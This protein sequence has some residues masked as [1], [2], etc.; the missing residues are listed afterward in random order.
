MATIKTS[1]T[2]VD[3][4]KLGILKDFLQNPLTNAEMVTLASTLGVAHKGLPVYNITDFKIY[5]WN[6]SAFTTNPVTQTGLTPK[7]SVAFN[8]TEPVAPVVGDLYVFTNAG[9]NIWEGNTVVQAS[10]QV[11]WDGTIWQFIQ[12]NVISASESVAG[13]IPIAT[14]AET[15]TGTEDLKAVTPLK[16]A[17]YVTTKKLSKTYFV[18]GVTL[19]ADTPFTI[20]HNLALQN[21]NAFTYNVMLTNSSIDVD[22]DSID[23]NSCSITSNVAAT[24]DVCIIGF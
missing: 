10:D 24:V 9:T 18:S 17:T 1:V 12:G 4:L 21:R 7:G 8:A 5:H 13:I 14:Q 16:L 3:F 20:T 11:W 23:A 22:V 15:N 6:G 2:G 19:V